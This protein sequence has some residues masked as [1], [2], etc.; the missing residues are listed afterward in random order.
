MREKGHTMKET[1]KKGIDPLYCMILPRYPSTVLCC[2]TNF[3]W[4]KREKTEKIKIL[5]PFIC[6]VGKEGRKEGRGVYIQNGE[7]NCLSFFSLAAEA[8]GWAAKS[9]VSNVHVYI[10]YICMHTLYTV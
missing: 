1:Q 4:K 10:L 8:M 7:G 6:S 2:D 9:V 3:R 5:H